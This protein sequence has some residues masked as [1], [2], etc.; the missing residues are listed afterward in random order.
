MGWCWTAQDLQGPVPRH[1]CRQLGSAAHSYVRG[2]R[3]LP[4]DS[5]E[6]WR[7]L[8]LGASRDGLEQLALHLLEHAGARA[9]R[10]EIQRDLRAIARFYDEEASE[11]ARARAAT[12]YATYPV[13]QEERDLL[14]ARYRR[15]G[16]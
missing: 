16:A 15:A 13:P 5:A 14:F 12:G 9:K 7:H 6:T 8:L 3:R 2:F 11:L 4:E 1:R 10:T